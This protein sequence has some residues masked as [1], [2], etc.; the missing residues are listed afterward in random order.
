MLVFNNNFKYRNPLQVV[1]LCGNKFDYKGTKDKRKV[2][3]NFIENSDSRNHVIILEENFCFT[4]TNKRY[5]SYDEIFLKNLAQVEQLASL[6][7]D[8][9]IIV[10]E[11]LSTSA[12]LGM[13]VADTSLTDKICLLVPD[14]IAVEENKIGGFIQ[15]AFLSSKSGGKKVHVIYYY[16]DIEVHRLSENKSFY[17]T[18]FHENKIGNFLGKEISSFLQQKIENTVLFLNK[19]FGKLSN[20]SIAI[21]YHISNIKKEVSV[22]VH[23]G[24]LKDQLFSLLFIPEV[25]RKLREEKKIYEHVNFLEIVYKQIVRDTISEIT[26]KKLD[27]F[28]LKIALKLTPCSLNQAIGYFIYMLQATKLI[29]LEQTSKTDLSKRKI[30][31]SVTLNRQ[32]VYFEKIINMPSKTVFERLVK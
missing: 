2:L 8:K 4:K 29:T 17:Y 1:F 5:L 30:A 28:A 14:R 27:N 6:F 21:D 20:Y 32:R 9:I 7:A 3:K 22:N 31:F 11:T 18:Y 24:I 15:L 12:E 19:Q 10:H 26:G 25:R 13:F 23:V 16:P